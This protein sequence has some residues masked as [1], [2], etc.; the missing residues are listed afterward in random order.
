MFLH[1]MPRFHSLLILLLI[2]TVSTPVTS[3]AQDILAQYRW[4]NRVVILFA[5]GV[6]NDKAAGFLASLS[7]RQPDFIDRDMLLITVYPEKAKI[8]GEAIS[9]QAAVALQNRYNQ[10]NANFRVL[11]IGKD[12]GVKLNRIKETALQNLFD[13]IDTM[14]MRRQ[15]MR[16][17][18]SG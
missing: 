6:D 4:Q 17:K 10:D 9:A 11:L 18:K 5:E 3:S 13:L 7:E 12:G 2:L 1:V 15:E 16:Q 8:A 14:P